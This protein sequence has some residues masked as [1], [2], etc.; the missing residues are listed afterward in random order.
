M[1]QQFS[2]RSHGGK[3]HI[4]TD[5]LSE[6]SGEDASDW[7]VVKKGLRIKLVT[8]KKCIKATPA[9]V[10]RTMAMMLAE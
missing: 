9:I 1:N 2:I 10:L 4:V 3:N 7:P 8:C 6:C 5:G